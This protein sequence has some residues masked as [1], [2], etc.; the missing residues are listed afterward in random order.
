MLTVRIQ[1]KNH[2]ESIMVLKL[3]D[4]ETMEEYEA[5]QKLG[6][7]V[8]QGYYFGKPVPAEV[9]EDKYLNSICGGLRSNRNRA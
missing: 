2:S 7:E 3:K 6:I 1:E 5:V 4:G 8:L 9:F